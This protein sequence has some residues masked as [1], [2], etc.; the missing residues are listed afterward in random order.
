M[1]VIQT[2]DAK[3]LIDQ[4]FWAGFLVGCIFGLVVSWTI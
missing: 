2:K 4:A 3:K 1:K